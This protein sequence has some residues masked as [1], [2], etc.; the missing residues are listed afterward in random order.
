MS[1]A[2][3]ASRTYSR[4]SLH[5][6]VAHEIGA[7]ILKGDLAPGDVLPNE[8]N[9]SAELNVSRTALREAIKVLAA[10]G[11][12]ESRPKTGTRV[13][14]R[15]V[16]NLLDPDIL[17]WQFSSGPDAA[18]MRHLFE[19]REIV[20]PAAAALAAARGNREEIARMA[21]AYEDMVAAGDDIEAGIEPDLRFHQSILAATENELLRS[22]GSMI[23]TALAAGFKASRSLDTVLRNSLPLHKKVMEA[24]SEGDGDT[25]R[26]T[27]Q[28]L[29]N[30]ARDG[31]IGLFT[32]GGD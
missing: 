28:I 25:A 11:L 32:E 3:A 15:E 18:V 22:L 8:A 6:Q 2:N 20:E 30:E 17:S 1:D 31:V 27:M 21:V 23:E 29:L 7:R 26:D 13:R 12:V 4:R 9:L 24:I 14:P 16:W 5:G 10:K 19:I